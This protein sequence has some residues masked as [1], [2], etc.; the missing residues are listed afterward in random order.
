[1]GSNRSRDKGEE[2]RIHCEFFAVK[3]TLYGIVHQERLTDYL[4]ELLLL[5]IIILFIVWEFLGGI[6]FYYGRGK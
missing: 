1:M 6:Y 3:E 5:P 4:I 2:M